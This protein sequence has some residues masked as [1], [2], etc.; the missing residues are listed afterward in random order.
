MVLRPLTKSRLMRW[1]KI[2]LWHRK[3]KRHSESSVN[4]LWG[5]TTTTTIPNIHYSQMDDLKFK[6]SIWWQHPTA[7]R[8][9]LFNLPTWL[10]D[11]M[12]CSNKP[13]THLH[14]LA[15][16]QSTS[17][18][19]HTN[20]DNIKTVQKFHPPPQKSAKSLDIRIDTK[21]NFKSVLFIKSAEQN[22]HNSQQ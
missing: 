5:T 14:P 10:T 2:K 16:S 17:A 9:D 8:F 12:T 21:K 7:T 15:F 1:I 19:W 22:T 18:K 3:L 20:L 6:W 4:L 13:H 11:H